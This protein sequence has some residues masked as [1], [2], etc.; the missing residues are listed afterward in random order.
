M[1]LWSARTVRVTVDWIPRLHDLKLKELL[2][3][4]SIIIFL[5]QKPFG[6]FRTSI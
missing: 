1:H 3:H 6:T 4:N 5:Y 2:E